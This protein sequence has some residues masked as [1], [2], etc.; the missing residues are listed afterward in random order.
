MRP[1]RQAWLQNEGLPVGG[2][3][4]TGSARRPDMAAQVGQK[5]LAELAHRLRQTQQLE[6]NARSETV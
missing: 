3:S 5:V 1:G 2:V 4:R 6:R